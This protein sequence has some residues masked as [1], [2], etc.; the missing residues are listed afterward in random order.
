MDPEREAN[1]AGNSPLDSQPPELRAINFCCL[2]HPGYGILLWWLKL[3]K[4]IIL[5]FCKI[6]M[7]KYSSHSFIFTNV[8]G[9]T[10]DSNLRQV[11]FSTF[12]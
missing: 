6:Y 10:F 3:T 2:N 9:I 7:F 1:E 8:F 4:A 12:L 11:G 5:L